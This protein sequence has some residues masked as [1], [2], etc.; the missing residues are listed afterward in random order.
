M[1]V[2]NSS[3]TSIA[4]LAYQISTLERGRVSGEN[5][6]WGTTRIELSKQVGFQLSDLWSA[7]DN[8][9]SILGRFLQIGLDGD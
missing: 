5:S 9:P 3:P 2:E 4:D 8:H 6:G 7:L 1:G